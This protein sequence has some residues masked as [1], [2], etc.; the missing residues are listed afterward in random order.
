MDEKELI[1]TDNEPIKVIQ[2]DCLEVMKKIPD[3]SIDAII[4][5]PPYNTGM[6][7]KDK[8]SIQNNKSKRVQLDAFF[9][10]DYSKEE[11]QSLVLN[12]CKE[13]HRIL[14]NDK[15][16]YICINWKSLG[17]WLNELEK[18]GFK[19]KNVIVWDKMWHGLNF[20]NYAYTYELII[21]CAKG[22]YFPNNKSFIDKEKGYFKDVWHIQRK[23]IE[24]DISKHETI[25]SKELIRRI[26][27]HA[28]NENDII[29]DAFL[30][31]GITA[32][33]CKEEKRKCIGIEINP[34]YIKDA[35]KLLRQGVLF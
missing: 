26:I 9:N 3:N 19:C 4:T 32:I 18:C 8:E 14:K 1:P 22:D 24:N 25:K 13:F 23:M 33:T 10:D 5:D 16:C 34:D 12:S 17:L 31:S 15:P 2:G 7:E 6:K 35:Q 29:L 21:F 20:Q 27:L 30:G 28:S 11:Y